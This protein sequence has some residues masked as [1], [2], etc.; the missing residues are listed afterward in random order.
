MWHRQYIIDSLTAN[1]KVSPPPLLSVNGPLRFK[2]NQLLHEPIMN[3]RRKERKRGRM[4]DRMDEQ[5]CI[6]VG[7]VPPTAVAV[8]GGLHHAP[9]R[10]QTTPDQAPPQT[11]TPREQTPPRSRHSP[12]NR[13]TD[14][15]KNITF[16]Q[17]RLRAVM[18]EER[19]KRRYTSSEGTRH[20]FYVLSY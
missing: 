7:C 1:I 6:P 5:E 15:C 4:T 20:F 17:L 9:P 2:E 3:V 8:G 13:I 16:P 18:M 10:E 14:T 11:G 19:N 12:V